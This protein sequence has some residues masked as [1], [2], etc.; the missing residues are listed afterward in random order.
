[1]IRGPGDGMPHPS[2]EPSDFEVEL[3]RKV[4]DLLRPLGL[5]VEGATVSS[6][7]DPDTNEKIHSFAFV[8]NIRES[9]RKKVVEDQALTDQFNKLM[10]DQA[11]AR[12][13]QEKKTIAANFDNIED[14]LFGD[15]DDEDTTCCDNPRKHP[16]DGFCINCGKGWED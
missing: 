8:A 4:V 16:T 9:A 5:T 11:N 15:D 1:M 13:E 7:I 14:F 3:T 2:Q 6:Y 12:I 10:A